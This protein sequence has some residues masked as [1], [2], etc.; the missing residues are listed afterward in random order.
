MCSTIYKI[1]Q[2]C[3]DINFFLGDYEVWFVTYFYLKRIEAIYLGHYFLDSYCVLEWTESIIAG[4][5]S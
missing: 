5:I 3:F 4:Y 1:E 2:I